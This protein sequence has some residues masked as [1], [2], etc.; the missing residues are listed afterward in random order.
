[1]LADLRLVRVGMDSEAVLAPVDRRVGLLGHDRGE[2]H[3]VGVQ[4]H[5]ALPSTASSAS[6]VTSSDRAQA[7]AATFSSLGA[8]TTTL[9]RFRNDLIT[10]CSWS[11][12]TTTTG[13]SFPHEAR[14]SAASF[15]EGASKLEP[16]STPNVP[17]VACE[18][19]A[20]RSAERR[21]LRFTFTSKLRSPV[22][23]ATPP[24]VQ[25]GARV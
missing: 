4:A 25:C 13:L 21:A 19:S 17:L 1:G 23:N 6:C 8:V 5:D 11:V 10:A 18:D 3:L 20:P 22:G 9:S 14:R 24:P 15:V 12:A 7:T 2:Q 16:S